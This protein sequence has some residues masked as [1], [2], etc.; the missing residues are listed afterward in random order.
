LSTQRTLQITRL[1]NCIDNNT[2]A[3]KLRILATNVRRSS[4][5]DA[6]FLAQAARA[7][8]KASELEYDL[9]YSV[10]AV[11]PSE[12]FARRFTIQGAVALGDRISTRSIT[13]IKNRGYVGFH[14]NNVINGFCGRNYQ[15]LVQMNLSNLTSEFFVYQY[16][17]DLITPALHAELAALFEQN[18]IPTPQMAA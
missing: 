16:C 10:P 6:E 15:R 5:N 14:V 7:E 8:A 12:Q 2:S 4:P 17:R 11:T 1:I 18:A 9:R 3:A 13:G